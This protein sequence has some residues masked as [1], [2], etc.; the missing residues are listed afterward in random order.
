MTAK[1]STTQITKMA[2][3]TAFISVSSY[4]VIP[5]PFTAISITGQTLAINLA[6]FV[7]TPGETCC[8]MICYWLLGLAGA[9]VFAGG[10]AGPGR[11]FSPMG[12]Y[13]IGFVVAAVLISVLKGKKYTLWKYACIGILIGIPIIDG[14]GCIWMK[15]AADMTWKAAFTA[16]VLPFIPLDIIKCGAAAMLA[17]PIR[18]A[19]YALEGGGVQKAPKAEG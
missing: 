18:S 19:F 16:S 10:T 11:M 12:G 5:L 2:L 8:T 9:P 7:L 15:Y 1:F 4:I 17:R 13:Y 6:A 3:M 14:I